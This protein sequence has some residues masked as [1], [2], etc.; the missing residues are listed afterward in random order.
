MA[1]LDDIFTTAKNIVLALNN[2]AQTA[3]DLS[4]RK[5]SLAM[6]TTTL[7]SA[8]PGRLVTVSIVVAGTGDGF[9]YDA[10][11]IAGATAE[12]KVVLIPQI[13]GMFSVGMPITYGIVVA[14]GTGQTIA[15]TYS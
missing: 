7:V 5:N 6:T 2:S 14:P 1:S 13:P 4:G 15:V 8:V 3:L 9:V 11:T 10:S 12:R